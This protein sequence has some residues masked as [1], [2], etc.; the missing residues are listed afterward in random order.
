MNSAGVP[1]GMLEPDASA[2][3]KVLNCREIILRY[4][5]IGSEFAFKRSLSFIL[6]Y[7][8]RRLNSVLR[9]SIRSPN[10]LHAVAAV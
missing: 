5:A 6:W 8:T 7:I 10:I 4:V 1:A 2:T 9:A 3:Q